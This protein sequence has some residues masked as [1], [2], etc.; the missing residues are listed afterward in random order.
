MSKVKGKEKDKHQPKS[1][2]SA[3][4]QF[5]DEHWMRK[6]LQAARKAETI[7]EVPVGAIIIQNNEVISIAY[8][9]KERLTSPLGHAELIAIHRA[10]QKLGAWRLS[11]CKL[12]VTLEPCPMCTG[13]LVQSRIGKVIFGAFDPKAGACG[14]ILNLHQN[15]QLNHRFAAIGGVLENE[16]SEILKNFFKKK[17]H[18]K[19]GQ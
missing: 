2:L 19:K 11:E 7:D 16:C 6:A 5:S 18:E 12:Y 4:P 1:P 8:N 17:R 14:S 13:A 15:A 3:D 9:Q 10:S